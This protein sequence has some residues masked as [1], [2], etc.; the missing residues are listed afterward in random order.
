MSGIL[1][2][3]AGIVLGTSIAVVIMSVL[4]TAAR[5]NGHE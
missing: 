1:V 3:T 2:F 4:F 5:G